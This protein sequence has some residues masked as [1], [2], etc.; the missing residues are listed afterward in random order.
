MEFRYRAFYEGQIIEGVIEGESKWEAAGKLRNQ[1]MLVLQLDEVS[2]QESKVDYKFL[3]RFTRQ[4]TQLLKS[5]L[6]TDRAI[7]FIYR[8][9]KKYAKQLEDV[10]NS[11]RE[12]SSLSNALRN[13]GIFPKSY[14][15][16]IRSGEESGSLEE[17]LELLLSAIIE[18][19]EMRRHIVNALVY[20]SFLFVISILSFLLISLYVIPKFKIVL[21]SVDVKLPL[22]TKIA[23]FVSDIFS[24]LVIAL[25]LIVLSSVLLF[26]LMKSKNPHLIESAVLKIPLIGSTILQLELIKF[27]QSMYFLL[28]SNIPLNQAID[29]SIG[30]V[31]FKTVREKLEEVKNEVVKG[32]GISYALS[33]RGLFPSV[34]IELIS[35]GEQT[36][37]L[38]GSF[39]RV[40]TQF[41]E[42][43]KDKAQKFISLLEPG[44][45]VIMGV[46]IGF[47]VFSM[48][49]AVFAISSG[50]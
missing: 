45:V 36:G 49:L 39:Y 4:L 6:T 29:I 34:F 42:E 20:P 15:E 9:E 3:E 35:V 2:P 5:G 23:F 32:S 31:N 47:L 40:Y 19:N 18:R 28:K 37:E 44:V 11:I 8:S 14:I 48:M 12:G 26:K 10:L 7:L 22:L 41:S 24:Y 27:S 1:G 43:F 30:T 17:I 13:T 16:M 50:I 38:Y 33:K 21:Q 46:V 25:I